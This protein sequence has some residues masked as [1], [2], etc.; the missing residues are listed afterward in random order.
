M[1]VSL[2]IPPSIFATPWSAVREE[3]SSFSEPPISVSKPPAI[4]HVGLEA[5]V[6]QVAAGVD[7]LALA[8]AV[9]DQAIDARPGR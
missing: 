6:E 2:P 1:I 3:R 8:L 7:D 5:A 4:E 9:P